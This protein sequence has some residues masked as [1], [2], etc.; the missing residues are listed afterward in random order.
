M[1]RSSIEFYDQDRVFSKM[2]LIEA[3]LVCLIAFPVGW[4]VRRARAGSTAI[5]VV[6]SKADRGESAASQA[7]ARDRGLPFVATSAETGAGA[8]LCAS[9][10]QLCMGASPALVP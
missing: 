6:A 9:G 1:I 8:W 3:I 5:V 4:W 2:L 7:W 10:S